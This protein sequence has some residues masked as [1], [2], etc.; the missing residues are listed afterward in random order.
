MA[1]IKYILRVEDLAIALNNLT[2]SKGLYV[3]KRNIEKNELFG[4]IKIFTIELLYK[5]IGKEI[6]SVLRSVRSN[7]CTTDV[8]E[9][10]NWNEVSIEFTKEVLNY[11][12]W[13][14]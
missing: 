4:A 6:V 8:E 7:K 10:N 3:I 13:K 11:I 5:E 14:K 12:K 1:N 2:G 9:L